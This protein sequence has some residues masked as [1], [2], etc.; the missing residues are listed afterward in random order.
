[1][2]PMQ[3]EDLNIYIDVVKDLKKRLMVSNTNLFFIT[4]GYSRPFLTTSVTCQQHCLIISNN[5]YFLVMIAFDPCSLIKWCMNG[6]SK[7]VSF[8]LDCVVKKCQFADQLK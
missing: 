4:N 7:D 8:S 3:G 1:M 2:R 6:D 5:Y